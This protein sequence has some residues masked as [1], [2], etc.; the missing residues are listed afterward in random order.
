MHFLP[1][2]LITVVVV[3]GLSAR[4]LPEQNFSLI[5]RAPVAAIGG[6]ALGLALC[7]IA[8]VVTRSLLLFPPP[9]H[10][11]FLDAFATPFRVFAIELWILVGAVVWQSFFLGGGRYSYVTEWRKSFTDGCIAS[12]TL[13][14]LATICFFPTWWMIRPGVYGK[15]EGSIVNLLVPTNTIYSTATVPTGASLGELATLQNLA[16]IPDA[17]ILAA[18]AS[19]ILLN[20]LIWGRFV[21]ATLSHDYLHVKRKTPSAAFCGNRYPPRGGGPN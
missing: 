18:I 6:Y 9:T 17:V 15:F 13:I 10:A 4:F 1:I 3:L 19:V 20:I 2:V 5:F 7:W 12:A 21:L 16:A 14:G 11:N 8:L